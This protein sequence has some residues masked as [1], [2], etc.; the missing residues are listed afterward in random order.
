MATKL[1]GW[2]LLGPYFAFAAWYALTL[3]AGTYSFFQRMVKTL[4]IGLVIE[5][6]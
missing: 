4:V 5:A 2:V 1:T 6:A 3:K